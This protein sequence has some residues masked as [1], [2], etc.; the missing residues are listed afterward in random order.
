[1][2]SQQMFNECIA[3][4]QSRCH[5]ESG[6]SGMLPSFTAS[7]LR[8]VL[9]PSIALAVGIGGHRTASSSEALRRI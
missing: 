9:P 2:H 1:M 6:R 3:R 7:F 5:N 4:H 8:R